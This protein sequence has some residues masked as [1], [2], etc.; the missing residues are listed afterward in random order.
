MSLSHHCTG[1]E[2]VRTVGEGGGVGGG[3]KRNAR[4]PLLVDLGTYNL[5]HISLSKVFILVQYFASII[6][7][8]QFSSSRNYLNV[9]MSA[10]I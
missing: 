2:Q 5:E 4:R 3:D 1:R 9:V 10:D 8:L 7:N 6:F